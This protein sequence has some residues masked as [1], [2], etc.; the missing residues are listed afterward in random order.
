MFVLLCS[1]FCHQ[2]FTRDP[3]PASIVDR[4]WERCFQLSE[5]QS[6]DIMTRTNSEH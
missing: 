4:I 5:V 1:R 2:S 3:C 6:V